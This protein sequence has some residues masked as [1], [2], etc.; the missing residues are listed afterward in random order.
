VSVHFEKSRGKYVVR[1]REDG[2]QRAR[3]FSD[4][5]AAAAFDAR[6]NPF[7]RGAQRAT[8]SRHPSTHA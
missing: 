7:G 3:R 8:T 6:V 4:E 2:K 5:S 1:W